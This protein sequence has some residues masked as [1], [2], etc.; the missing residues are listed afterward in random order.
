MAE[1]RL[2]FQAE[3]SKLLH[4]VAN[5]LYSEKEI[6]L[7]E[8]ISNA[9]D[10]C[11]RL[12][13]LALTKPELTA[14]DPDFRIRI[15]IDQKT[16]T[17]K[18]TDNGIGM[19]RDE[20]IE[21][22]G[23]IARS[24][25]TQFVQDLEE[26]EAK[27]DGV[28]LIG[29]FGVGFYSGFIVAKEVTV[30]SRKAGE[31]EAWTWTSDGLGAFTVTEGTQEGRGTTVS[32]KLKKGEEEFLEDARL[33]HIV[34][35]YSDHIALPITLASESADAET[36]LNTA[37]ALWT[38]P[39]KDITEEQYKEFY[40]HVGH[41]FDDPW[42][43]LHTKAEGKIEY[44]L[45][46]FVP[47]TRPLDLF[48]PQRKG[49]LKLYVKRVFITDD[50]DELVPSYLRFLRGVVDCE[51][52]SLNISREMLQNNPV[53]LKI[54]KALVKRVL[55]ELA[56]KAEKTPEE[57]LAFWDNFGAP[58]KEGV[59][60]DTEQ[61]EALLELARFRSTGASDAWVSLQDYV[62]RMK[63]GQDEIYYISGEDADGLRRSPQIEGFA[64]KGLEVLLMTDPIDEF[65]INAIGEYQGKRLISAT[66]GTIDLNKFEATDA[67]QTDQPEAAAEEG[68][69]ALIALL[70]LNLDERVKDV[71]ASERLTESPVCLVADE[72][73][74]DMHLA[75]LL[76]QHQQLDQT[77][78]RI[79]EINPR[80]ELIKILAKAV[81]T[82]GAADTLAD[83]AELLLEQALILEGEPLP[84]PAGFSRRL[85]GVM[86][87]GLAA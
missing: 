33:R 59:Y 14:D 62:G 54:R 40:H 2:D 73:D 35:T 3:V 19:S 39:K 46:L 61:R 81:S 78:A 34:K 60:E 17:L 45:L 44:T 38:R 52:L 67:A 84:D 65:W 49:R 53:V 66:R 16:K 77:A 30:E 48:D 26:D 63:E 85:T 18:V 83:A 27:A 11:D 41:L 43:T 47:S 23:T 12:R 5:S 1:E 4:I 24:G 42:L 22:L 31:A 57:Y 56:K 6:F 58:L 7:R 29:Q 8:L 87:R 71:R 72:G 70:K 74:V 80:H 55:K 51:D 9:S 82:E 79:L 37:S 76:K 28:S 50:C 86:A 32:L 68:V 10:A 36:P 64:A 75:R 25:T 20:L 13:Y 69:N 21:N 15:E